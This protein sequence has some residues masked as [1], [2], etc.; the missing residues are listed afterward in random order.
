MR[1]VLQSVQKAHYIQD[2]IPLILSLDGNFDSETELVCEH[3]EWKHGSKEIIKH[4]ANLGLKTHLQKCAA[5]SIEY[6]SV[7]LLEDDLLVSPNFY[8]YACDALQFYKNQEAIASVSLYNYSV[9]ECGFFPFS[10]LVDGFDNY[11]I[12]YVSSWG[13]AITDKQWSE[14]EQWQDQNKIVDLP[15]YIKNWGDNSWK[16][17]FISYMIDAKKYSVFPRVSLTTNFSESG[18]HSKKSNLFQVQMEI[19][20]NNRPYSFSALNLSNSVYDS[21]FELEPYIVKN[22]NKELS[23][24]DFTTDL[25]GQRPIESNRFYLS[26]RQSEQPI[27]SFDSSLRPL[28]QN[29][30]FNL[31]GKNINLSLGEHLRQDGL[32]I[33]NRLPISEFHAIHLGEQ[34]KPKKSLMVFVVVE[35]VSQ[36][37]EAEATISSFK[38][39]SDRVG[40]LVSLPLGAELNLEE[41]Y[42]EIFFHEPGSPRWNVIREMS[43]NSQAELA[44]CINPGQIVKT[45][46]LELALRVF[47]SLPLINCLAVNSRYGLRN[48]FRHNAKTISKGRRIYSISGIF[49]KKDVLKQISKSCITEQKAIEQLIQKHKIST[50]Y[51]NDALFVSTEIREPKNA[52]ST[53][54][55]P[56]FMIQNIMLYCWNKNIPL[57]RSLLPSIYHIDPVLKYHERYNT[58][59]FSPYEE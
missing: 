7:I 27:V 22:Y 20:L 18:T 42:L 30:V 14:F 15:S 10:P 12:Q 28:E 2:N 35:D 46:S 25:N 17:D 53:W 29:V 23:K 21:F 4:S 43:E 41:Y 58:F 40:L 55:K 16:K 37:G 11:F 49:L 44:L 52:A 36:I 26:T 5:L 3:F 54:F 59:Y 57:L 56:I 6:G 13:V 31:P 8:K 51:L 45:E 47:E 50:L 24:F 19:Q 33:L 39:F 9:S 34:L 32:D 48:K 1:R 38:G